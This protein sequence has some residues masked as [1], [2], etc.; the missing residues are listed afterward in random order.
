MSQVLSS[1]NGVKARKQCRC[2]LC[3]ERINVGDIKDVRSG[4]DSGD[5]WTMNMHPEC[6]KYETD[7]GTFDTDWYEDVSDPAFKRE[8]AIKFCETAALT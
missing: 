3:G 8:D 1:K 5:M 7:S 4:V 2:C 6:H